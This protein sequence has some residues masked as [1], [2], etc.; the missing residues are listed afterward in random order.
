VLSWHR[1]HI[2]A[3]AWWVLISFLEHA[4]RVWQLV[5]DAPWQVDRRS[6]CA[7]IAVVIVKFMALALMAALQV[8]GLPRLAAGDWVVIPARMALWSL[9]RWIV[10]SWWLAF[11]M[12]SW[13]CA[14]AHLIVTHPGG[15]AARAAKPQTDANARGIPSFGWRKM[16]TSTAA[17]VPV[18][19]RCWARPR[20]AA[21]WARL[22]RD[23]RRHQLVQRGYVASVFALVILLVFLRCGA[24]MHRGWDMVVCMLASP[25]LTRPIGAGRIF[26]LFALLGGILW[27][28][29]LMTGARAT[30]SSQSESHECG[31]S[32]ASCTSWEAQQSSRQWEPGWEANVAEQEVLPH[33]VLD[34]LQPGG[35]TT[36]TKDEAAWLDT[37]LNATFGGHPEFQEQ[38][39]EEMRAILRRCG[40]C[41]ANT[42]QDIKGYHGD[43]QHNTFSI[44]FK[45]ESKAAYQRPRKYSPGEQEIIDIHCKE[46][47]EYG[48]IEPA[49]KHCRHASN[50]V[51]AG[52]KDHETGLWTQTRFCVDLRNTNRHSLKD[53]TLPH[54]PE[55]LYQKVAKAKFKTTLDATKAFHQIPMATEEDRDKT[56]FWWRNQL[57]RYTSMPFGAAGAT[58]AFIRVMDYELR[59]LQHCTVAYVDDVVIYS[60]TAEQHLKDVEQTLQTLGDAGIR[61]HSGKS[62]FGAATVDFLGFRIGQNTIGAQE[63]KCKAIQDLPKPEDKTGLRSILGMMNYYKGLVGEPG[64]PNYSELHDP[65]TI[66]SRRRSLT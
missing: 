31:W 11:V 66:C 35:K 3:W 10:Q 49:S 44:P 23:V 13:G 43:A 28:T 64:G 65:S 1:E 47:L 7:W 32:R 54:R 42:P 59:H 52:K 34:E 61:L 14:L 16:L 62:T 24:S 19:P 15:S 26:R 5:L 60:D 53:N 12:V 40:H 45:D 51:V 48:F 20:F 27:V 58:A 9:A 30:L 29:S 25:S 33:T 6:F 55:E 39:W 38:H 56:A 21:R 63:A 36:V 57:Y 2:V 22:R 4:A 8:A 46:L 41:F 18:I 17:V 50:V 37:E